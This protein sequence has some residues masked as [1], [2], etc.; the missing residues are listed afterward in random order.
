MRIALYSHQIARYRFDRAK[1][2]AE[3]REIAYQYFKHDAPIV[4]EEM[5]KRLEDEENGRTGEIGNQM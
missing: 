1:T 2:E 5:K 4:E 3:Q